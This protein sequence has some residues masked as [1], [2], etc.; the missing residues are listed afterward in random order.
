MRFIPSCPSSLEVTLLR[1]T[2][3]GQKFT[4]TV[5]DCIPPNALLILGRTSRLLR[6]LVQAYAA[7]A[8]NTEATLAIWFPRVD[9]AKEAID[10]CGAVLGGQA[11]FNFFNRN[12]NQNSTLRVFL[13]IGGA[14]RMGKFLSDAG[15][16]AYKVD[17]GYYHFPATALAMA[18]HA[19]A[20]AFSSKPDRMDPPLAEF[21]FL[22]GY[23]RNPRRIILCFVR[24]DPIQYILSLPHSEFGR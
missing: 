3:H 6:G 19:R 22:K 21:Q 23:H 13:Q 12:G 15:Y 1:G 7:T 20:S 11:M 16:N 17:T 4:S 24:A 9:L 5:L 10:D 8:W 2:R 18:L 14:L